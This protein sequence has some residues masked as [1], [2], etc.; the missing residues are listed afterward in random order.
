MDAVASEP[1]GAEGAAAP[2][3]QRGG[4]CPLD[5]IFKKRRI[6]PATVCSQFFQFH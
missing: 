3:S 4:R 6:A 2:W 5:L 1:G